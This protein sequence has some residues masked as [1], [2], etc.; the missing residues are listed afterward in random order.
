MFHESKSANRRNPNIQEV[1]KRTPKRRKE[2]KKDKG[3][4]KTAKNPRNPKQ[5]HNNPPPNT[6]TAKKPHKNPLP[7]KDYTIPKT[8]RGLQRYLQPISFS[9]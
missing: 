6:S 4:K 3:N 7:H 2:N 1:Y 8:Q 9:V 5:T